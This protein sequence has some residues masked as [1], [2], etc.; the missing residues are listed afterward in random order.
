MIKNFYNY[1]HKKFYF[2]VDL[3]DNYEVFEPTI[4]EI[5][6]NMG[7]VDMYQILNLAMNENAQDM[8]ASG[9]EIKPSKMCDF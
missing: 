1:S 5:Y 2:V 9:N 8:I 6:K 4:N 7:T 3:S